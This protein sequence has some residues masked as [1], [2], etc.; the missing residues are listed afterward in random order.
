MNEDEMQAYLGRT[1]DLL[2]APTVAKAIRELH[3][4]VP[5]P[6]LVVHSKHWALAVGQRAASLRPALVGGVTMASTRY[7]M[8]DGFTAEDYAATASLTPGTT[9]QRLVSDVADLLGPDACVVPALDLTGVATP[10]TIGLG[11]SFVGGFLAALDR[12]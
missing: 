7:W 4:V 8:G 9:A 11:D 12:R 6:T 10:T 1:V 3:D 2:D 5:A